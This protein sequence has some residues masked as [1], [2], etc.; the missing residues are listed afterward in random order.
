MVHKAAHERGA[1]DIL[2]AVY[3]RDVE[4]K[5]MVHVGRVVNRGLILWRR[6][7]GTSAPTTT[8]PRAPTL[9]GAA[10]RFMTLSRAYNDVLSS[11]LTK[12]IVPTE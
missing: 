5:L 10:Q 12:E 8:A 7:D 1:H 4:R 6:G 11:M 3:Q 9:G 2:L